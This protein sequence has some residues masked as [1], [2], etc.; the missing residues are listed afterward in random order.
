MILEAP[1]G[2]ETSTDEELNFLKQEVEN[3]KEKKELKFYQE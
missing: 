3:D 2:I 1:K